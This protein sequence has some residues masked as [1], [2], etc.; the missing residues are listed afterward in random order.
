MTWSE[1]LAVEKIADRKWGAASHPPLKWHGQVYERQGL[2][3]TPKGRADVKT[4]QMFM[5]FL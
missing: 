5:Q 4:R 3:S 1:S 2:L